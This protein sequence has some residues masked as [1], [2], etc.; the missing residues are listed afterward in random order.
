MAVKKWIQGGRLATGMLMVQAIATGL[1]LLSRLILNQGSFIFAY[2]FYRHVV[3]AI[4]VAPFALFW[5]RGNG[6]K[7]SWLIFFWL[8]V[9]ALTGITMAMG[10]FYYGLGDTTATYTTNFLNLIPIVTFLLSTILRIEELRLNTRAGKIKT[11]AAI[12]CL[13]GA[14]VIAFYKGKAFHVPHLNVEKLSILKTTK[15]REWTR[16]TIFLVCSCLS[17]SLCFI[18]Q[19]KLFQLFPYK[20]WSTFYTCIIASVQQ[21]AVGLCIDRSKAAWHLGWNLELV[22]IFYSGSLATSVSF[23]LISW[24]ISKRGPTYPSMF[25]PLSLVFVAIAE[26]FFLGEVI[27]IGSLLG[28]FLIIVGLYSFLWA[29]NKETKAIFKTIRANGEVEKR[30]VESATTVVPALSPQDDIKYG[31]KEQ[32]TDAAV[33]TRVEGLAG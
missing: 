27:T 25:N 32:Q 13:G 16:G 19:V 29:K 6:K 2:V 4:C 7:L 9:V 28:M 18:S 20:F 26:A 3:G 17:Y 22:T 10:L 24:A 23:C 33:L 14:L 30:S 11:M 31:N 8:F 1:Q 21:V 5:E 12:L 15:P